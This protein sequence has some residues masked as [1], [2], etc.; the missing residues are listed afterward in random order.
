MMRGG[1]EGDEEGKGM[2]RGGARWEQHQ[3][4]LL[5]EVVVLELLHVLLEHAAL[6]HRPQQVRTL[7][8]AGPNK[9][10]PGKTNPKR[11]RE[12]NPDLARS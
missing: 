4:G 10:R 12:T 7:A 1:G 6:L 3:P 2:K 5:M 11:R 8:W 9:I